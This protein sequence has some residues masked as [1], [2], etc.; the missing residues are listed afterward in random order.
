MPLYDYM[1]TNGHVTEVMH[2]VNDSGPAQ[3]PQCGA[4]MRKL[5]STPA[6]VFKGSGWAKKDRSG[7]PATKKSTTDTEAKPGAS[8]DAKSD[9]TTTSSAPTSTDNDG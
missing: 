1:C 8:K 9:T 6:I 7:K 3:C 5:M 2:G 4:E